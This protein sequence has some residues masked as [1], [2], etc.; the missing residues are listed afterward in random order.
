MARLNNEK[1]ETSLISHA[2]YIVFFTS[3]IFF[4]AI[5]QCSSIK[6]FGILPDITFCMVC[7][8]GFVAKE[9]YGGIFGLCGGVLIMALGSSGLSLAPVLFTFCG[10]LSGVLPRIALRRNFL[11]YLIF[12]PLMGAIHVFFTFMYYIMASKSSQ[13]WNA[14]GRL[15]I[16][17]FFSCIICLIPA[18]FAVLGVYTLFKGKNNRIG[19]LK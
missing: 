3:F 6:L 5:L 14:I 18:Y 15:I 8:I 2:L 1:K 7:A 9:K 12:A 13:I 10:Y 11:S 17:E 19:N 4:C 16:P